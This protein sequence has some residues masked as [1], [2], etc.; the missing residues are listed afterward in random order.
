ME[1]E[2]NE[3]I[4]N[5]VSPINLDF[6]QTRMMINHKFAQCLIVSKYPTKPEYGWLGKIANLEGTTT[7]TT[8]F[9][10]ESAPLIEVLNGQIKQLKR[11]IQGKLDESELQKKDKEIK[12]IKKL[13]ARVQNNELVGYVSMILLVQATSE[14]ELSDR[15]K[16]V[17]SKIAAMDG[18]T[19]ILSLMQKEGYLAITPYGIPNDEICDM[20]DR[21]MPLS[22]LL[23]GF[24]NNSEGINDQA[25]MK[26]GSCDGKPVIIDDWIR[27]NDRTNGNW[28]ITGVPGVGKTT[29]VKL[30]LTCHYAL[31]AKIIV[32]DPD[33][34]YV[35]W[36][37]KLKA[38]IVECGGGRGRFN[39][40]QVR[41]V[42]RP[43]EEDEEDDED[44]EDDLYMD[45]GKGISDVAFHYQ[46]FRTWLKLYKKDYQDIHISIIERILETTYARFNI[47]W[48]TD[49]TK[50]KP[51]DY[52]I[53]SDLYDDILEEYK[54]NS[55]SQALEYIVETFRSCAYGADAKLFNG[56][57]TVEMNSD[58]VILSTGSL[59][60]A[61][62]A[63]M[64]A[65][66]H[67]INSWVWMICSRD[68]DEKIIYSIDEGYLYVDS[69][70]PDIMKFIKI[71]TKRIR[72]YMGALLF[73]THSVVDILD[74]SVRKHGQ[75]IID[76]ATYKFLMGADG[77]NLKDTQ[78]LFNL[79]N[80]EVNLLKSKIRGKGLLFVGSR[81][82]ELDVAV[83]EKFLAL[84]GKGGGK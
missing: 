55:S 80:N 41:P 3:S 33:G 28:L 60:N 77:K 52:P 2:V 7:E 68:R 6:Y 65:Q 16:R 48:K 11:D 70:Y 67:N 47:F 49:I 45:E 51:T 13:I 25:G 31:G 23:G 39:I 4:L 35:E 79:T 15:V 59:L 72:K 58:I 1:K 61:D 56:H 44:D 62:D 32:N 34:E 21:P 66:F 30:I 82:F 9:P 29:F 43:S 42:P 81:R 75:A 84:M 64:K 8:F 83:P 12:H 38:K 57:T 10:T 27:E 69:D 54:K 76:S 36:G 5:I 40:L 18:G 26:L 19:R 74:K 24:F 20:A 22:T 63:I 78:D 14:K 50:L 46:T 73:I 17:Q 53:L 71:F 37:K